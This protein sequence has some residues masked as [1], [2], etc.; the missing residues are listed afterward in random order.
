MSKESIKNLLKS[1]KG[2]V[3]TIERIAFFLKQ[4]RSIFVNCRK[5]KEEIDKNIELN[6]KYEKIDGR[7]YFWFSPE[8]KISFFKKLKEKIIGV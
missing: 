3:F 4:D 6:I 1:Q 2:E 5:L 7:T 8:T